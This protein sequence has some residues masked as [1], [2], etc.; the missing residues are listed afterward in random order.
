MHNVTTGNSPD[1]SLNCLHQIY[2]D[3][4]WA[5]SVACKHACVCVCVCGRALCESE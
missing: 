3:Y 4:I 1:L 2:I 5:I